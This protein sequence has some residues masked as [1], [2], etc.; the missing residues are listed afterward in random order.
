M[1]GLSYPCSTSEMVTTSDG[2]CPIPGLELTSRPLLLQPEFLLRS[3]SWSPFRSRAEHVHK[4]KLSRVRM[5]SICAWT[6]LPS[7]WG[8]RGSR[9]SGGWPTRGTG[10]RRSGSGSSPGHGPTQDSCNVIIVL[11]KLNKYRYVLVICMACQ[12]PCL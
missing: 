9:A 1:V 2:Y 5:Y 11:I 7:S 6:I 4:L 8:G 10:P 3:V 12:I